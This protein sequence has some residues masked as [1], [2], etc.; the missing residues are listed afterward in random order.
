[1][2]L[3]DWLRHLGNGDLFWDLFLFMW[4]HDYVFLKNTFNYSACP[5]FS[6]GR[7]T[8]WKQKENLL[9]AYT[10]TAQEIL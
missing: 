8:T 6:H 10:K 5:V 9:N 3:W 7:E 1:M 4:V 2:W